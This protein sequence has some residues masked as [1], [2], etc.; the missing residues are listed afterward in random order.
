[1]SDQSNSQREA[2]REAIG[3]LEGLATGLSFYNSNDRERVAGYIRDEI[4]HLSEQLVDDDAL[5]AV[6]DGGE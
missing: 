4:T 3:F 6:L 1:V 2:L 5:E